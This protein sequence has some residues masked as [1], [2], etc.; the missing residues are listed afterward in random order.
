MEKYIYAI[1][2]TTEIG[3][4][5]GTLVR[6]TENGYG[7]EHGILNILGETNPFYAFADSNGKYSL[8]VTLKT[9]MGERRFEGEGYVYPDKLE[10]RL[11]GKRSSCLMCGTIKEVISDDE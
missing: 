1:N 5:S 10:I 4:K 11:R 3:S 6:Y 2:L 7:S 8:S 9:L